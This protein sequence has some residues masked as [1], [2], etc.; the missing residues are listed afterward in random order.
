MRVQDEPG[1]FNYN[2][3]TDA[4]KSN[5]AGKADAKTGTKESGNGLV[6][7]AA[8]LNLGNESIEEK[9]R[10]AQ[11]MALDIV[12][13]AFDGDK[14]IDADLDE[15]RLRINKLQEENNEYAK[16][17][18][19]ID[20]F[21]ADVTEDYGVTE[22]SQE[23]ADLELL[24]KEREAMKNMD[25]FLTSFTEEEKEQLAIIKENGI[26]DYQQYMLDL[27]GQ[28]EHFQGKIDENIEAIKEENA[29]ITGVKLERLKSHEM[30][31]A[32]KQSDKIMDAA[33]E[34]IIGELI[35]DAKENVDERLK[36]DK[37]NAEAAEEKAE[38]LEEKLDEARAERKA[39]EEQLEEMCKLESE[40]ETVST[41][42][43]AENMPD[44]KKSLES[45]VNELKL[46]LQDLT[47]A[48]V[49][50]MV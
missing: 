6:M 16:E 21:R 9:R 14:K 47:G 23:Q 25:P 36:E 44:V 48:V 43:Q 2:N 39:R 45:V 35:A 38:E 28:E 13:E 31:D 24:R 27:D 30:V 40:L 12:S 37:E 18:K 3:I 42:K 11:R 26:T 46:T 41:A 7:S 4:G 5:Q 10:K 33:S 34:S 49:D 17:L 22:D 50:D 15:R 19:R 29:I 20:E 8:K 1:I 32:K